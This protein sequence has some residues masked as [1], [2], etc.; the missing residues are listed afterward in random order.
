[1]KL[2]PLMPQDKLFKEVFPKSDIF[3]YP[4]FSDTFGFA[5]TEAIS[6]GVPVVTVDGYSRREIITKKTKHRYPQYHHDDIHGI[7]RNQ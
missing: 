2:L 7:V 4:G 6:F 3:V 1:M 5:L